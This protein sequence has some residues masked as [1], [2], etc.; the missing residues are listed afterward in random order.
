MTLTRRFSITETTRHPLEYVN[1]NFI[2]FKGK[3]D[4][5]VRVVRHILAVRF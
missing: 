1:L 3:K 5:R 2:A 4:E